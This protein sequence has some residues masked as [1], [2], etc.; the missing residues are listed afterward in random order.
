MMQPVPPCAAPG[1][2]HCQ[3]TAAGCR[4]CAQWPS[5]SGPCSNFR[6]RSEKHSE[7]PVCHDCLPYD[8]GGRRI[9]CPVPNQLLVLQPALQQP[10]PAPSP[11]ALHQPPHPIVLQLQPPPPPTWGPPHGVQIQ[12]PPPP[13]VAHAPYARP[14]PPGLPEPASAASSGSTSPIGSFHHATPIGAATT[15][16][17]AAATSSS[18][19]SSQPPQHCQQ[20]HE[21]HLRTRAEIIELRSIVE[22]LTAQVEG[23]SPFPT[24]IERVAAEVAE[25]PK[26]IADVAAEVANLRCQFDEEKAYQ[27]QWD[28]QW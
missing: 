27:Q 18:H 26:T 20:C 17:T 23:L 25:L 10:P 6:A 11:S 16:A 14:R 13:H 12:P 15:S 21:H 3:G 1:N 8:L 9:C 4:A 24:I 5:R 2:C 7:Y 22:R 28:D 19:S